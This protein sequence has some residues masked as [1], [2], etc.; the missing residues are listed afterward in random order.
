MDRKRGR[1]RLGRGH[2]LRKGRLVIE[3]GGGLHL[4]YGRRW[5]E[6]GKMMAQ[7]HWELKMLLSVW[8]CRRLRAASAFAF[9]NAPN[10]TSTKSTLSFFSVLTPINRGL[11]F[12]AATTS[13]G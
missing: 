2:R 3:S 10:S 13:L 6:E 1:I 9:S 7:N 11:P 8:Y 12:R 4:P 5:V